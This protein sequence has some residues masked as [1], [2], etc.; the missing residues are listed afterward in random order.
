MADITLDPD[1]PD[2]LES[3]RVASSA[4][5]T[6][7]S[8]VTGGAWAWAALAPEAA[9]K[10]VNDDNASRQQ[11]CLLVLFCVN[12]FAYFGISCP[13][14][15]FR[16]KVKIVHI[17]C[18]SRS[19]YDITAPYCSC[20]TCRVNN[21]LVRL[22]LAVCSTTTTCIGNDCGASISVTTA[23]IIVIIIIASNRQRPSAS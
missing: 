14:T 6:A 16:S 5:A 1:D 8:T 23:S 21:N 18:C 7:S 9:V 19:H 2:D 22:S 4:A 11:V 20:S 15:C 13:L 3:P 12:L 17:H 10:N